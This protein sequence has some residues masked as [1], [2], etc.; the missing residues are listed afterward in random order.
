MEET[1]SEL[2]SMAGR[3]TGRIPAEHI[4]HHVVAVTEG[5]DWPLRRAAMEA[6]LRRCK[7]E[8]GDN[9]AGHI[10]TGQR[11]FRAGK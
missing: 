6:I 7:F 4:A 10:E 5:G 2:R 1:L 8:R 11:L 9:L 3:R